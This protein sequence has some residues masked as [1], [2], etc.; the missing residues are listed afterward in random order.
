[1]ES[2]S[3]DKGFRGV[4]K[5]AEI[6]DFCGRCHAGVKEDY[7]ESAHGAALGSGGPQC[8]TCHGSHEIRRTT[9]DLI[10]RET[11][12]ACHEYGRADEIRNALTRTDET[13]SGLENALERLHRIGIDTEALERRVFSIRN[14]FHRLFHSVNVER[15]RRETSDFLDRL[16]EV[17]QSISEI[18]EQLAFRARMGGIVV[19]L[20]FL[21]AILFFYL[22]RLY[23]REERG[24]GHG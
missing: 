6:P 21:A 1:M 23:H 10:N 4:P 19:G 12:T 8:V 11:C 22:R 3:G 5:E 9:L 18:R 20:L 17:E 14:E 24:G 13:I 2:M 7:L 15:I 16:S